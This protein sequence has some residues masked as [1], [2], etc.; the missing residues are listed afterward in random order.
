MLLMLSFEVYVVNFVDVVN[1]VDVVD[2]VDVVLDI[3]AEVDFD[4]IIV[5][6]DV[7]NVVI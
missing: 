3:V 7:V 2:F 4:V 1:V 6:V 5:D